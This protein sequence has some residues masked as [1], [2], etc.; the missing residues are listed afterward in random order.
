[1]RQRAANETDEDRRQGMVRGTVAADG[2]LH[3]IGTKA[4]LRALSVIR[5]DRER[6]LSMLRSRPFLAHNDAIEALWGGNEDGGPLYAQHILGIYVSRLRQA[7]YLIEN[8]RGVG[9]RIQEA[10]SGGAPA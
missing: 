6:L 9:Y 5:T 4:L 10:A 8:Y 1:M 3:V 7:G 2:E